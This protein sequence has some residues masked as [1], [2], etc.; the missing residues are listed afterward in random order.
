MIKQTVPRRLI[1]PNH[2][3]GIRDFTGQE[4]TRLTVT[5]YHSSSS[6]GKCRVWWNCLCVCGRTVVVRADG[7]LSGNHQS[8]GCLH[9]ERAGSARRR[10]GRYNTKIYKIWTAMLQRCE[11]PADRGYKNYGGRGITVDER[12]HSFEHFYEDMGDRPDGM[13]L[14]RIDNNKGYAKNNCKWAT[15]I[16]QMQ[17]LRK[18]RMITYKGITLC[19]AEWERKM[20][21]KPSVI[22]GRL[23][24]GWS[25][26]D[27][28]N[29]P[30]KYRKSKKPLTG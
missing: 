26:D 4:F 11:N 14:E 2:P 13:S 28:I 17:N 8:C 3:R 24:L 27:A 5:S 23:V 18:N 7:L 22:A 1:L 15:K 10:H 12:W 29:T 25:I 9:R 16:E 6:D 21:Y 20:G 30:P 19:V